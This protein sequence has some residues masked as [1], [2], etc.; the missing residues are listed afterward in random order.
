MIL[1]IPE[2]G[3]FNCAKL[4]N[5]LAEKIYTD[6]MRTHPKQR[7]YGLIPLPMHCIDQMLEIDF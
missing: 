5:Y 2:D 4:T 6:A 7:R 1:F 3:L